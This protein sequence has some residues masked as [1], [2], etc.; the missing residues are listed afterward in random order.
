MKT[1]HFRF[2][3]PCGCRIVAESAFNGTPYQN[4][5]MFLNARKT[6]RLYESN[7]EISQFLEENKEDITSYVDQELMEEIGVVK[8]ILGDYGCINGDFCLIHHVWVRGQVD[9]TSEE[10]LSKIQ[11][12]IQS[13]LS[14]GWGESLEQ[15]CAMT[16]TVRWS[17]PYYDDDSM[18]WAEE[19]CEDAVEYLLDPWSQVYEIEVFPDAEEEELDI[20]GEFVASMKMLHKHFTRYVVLVRDSAEFEELKTKVYNAEELTGLV[21]SYAYPMLIPLSQ[22]EE[23]SA[24]KPYIAAYRLLAHS[25]TY[26]QYTIIDRDKYTEN[27]LKLPL[28]DAIIELLKR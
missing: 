28:Y 23:Y 13:Q 25:G 1:T 9:E 22:Y 16:E 4:E 27:I 26:N 10:E 8:M 15:K 19:E 17:T 18:E 6:A 12:Y 3:T 14:D 20:A 2:R 7:S 11:D 5:G 21:A 24:E